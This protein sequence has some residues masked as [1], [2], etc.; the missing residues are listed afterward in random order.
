M[1]SLIVAIDEN[2]L[3]GNNGKIPW[4]NKEDLQHF[5]EYTMGKPLLVGRKTFEGFPKP[6]PNR[7]HYV[8]SRRDMSYNH[9]MVIPIHDVKELIEKYKNSEEELVV[10]G[11]GEIYKLMMPYIDKAVISVMD[12]TYEGDTYFPVLP[13]DF[14]LE[15]IVDKNGFDIFY[16][17]RSKTEDQL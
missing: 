10:I 2:R 17:I 11:G 8:L 1:I 6:L 7:V 4:H 3:I 5:K 9:E 13:K 14:D 15:E 12:G 16:F